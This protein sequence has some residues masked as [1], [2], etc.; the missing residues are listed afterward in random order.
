MSVSK[1][2]V[3]VVE[4]IAPERGPTSSSDYNAVLQELINDLTQFS[5]S[6][7]GEVQ[8]LLDTLP[9]GRTNI[10]RE[11]RV[12]DPN[13][14]INGFDGSQVYL[15]LTS[16]ILTDNG[17][18]FDEGLDRP[19]TIKESME[20]VQ[21]Q[22]NDAIQELQVKIAQVSLNSGITSRQRQAIGSRIFDPETTS[23][24]TSLDGLSQSHSRSIDQ[25]ALDLSGDSE[26]LDGS[27]VQ[28][29]AHAVLDV[30]DAIKATHDYDPV[31]NTMSH[32]NLNLHQHRYHV[33]PVGA[34]NGLNKE[35]FLPGTEVFVQGTL[36]VMVNG[37]EEQKSI[38]YT[39]R[40]D[41]RGFTLTPSRDA[42]ENNASGADDVVW[43]HYDVEV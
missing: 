12:D 13:P 43:I 7:N 40:P 42:L 33:V 5:L 27:G 32:G 30:L 24:P 18:Y 23:G 19:L 31:F 14:F 2:D 20:N 22:L 36:R 28:T 37:L 8:P 41:F 17:K 1:I 26:Y 38:N 4:R 29:L 34:L 6:W 21:D 10:V 3:S 15:D 9:A 11:D 16:T 25:I 39:E 35:Y